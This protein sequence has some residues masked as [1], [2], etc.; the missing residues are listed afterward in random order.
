MAARQRR[1]PAARRAGYLVAAVVDVV[2]LVLLLGSPGWEAVPVLT[3]DT[4]LVLGWV[5]ASLVV[6]AA[7]GLLRVVADPPWFVALGDVVTGGVGVVA[8]LRVWQVFPFDL[9]AGW[10]TL[11]RVLLLVALVGGAV[12][13]VVALVRLVSAAGGGTSPHVAGRGT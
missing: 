4:T 8:T 10:E 2:V 1:R 3:A 13:T 6:G 12:G 11:A 9:A 7:V 5:T